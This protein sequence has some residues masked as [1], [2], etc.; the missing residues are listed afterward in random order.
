MPRKSRYNLSDQVGRKFNKL[1][2]VRAIA[3]KNIHCECICGGRVITTIY[4][5]EYGKTASCGC[6]EIANRVRHGH[7][8]SQGKSKEYLVWDGMIQRCTNPNSRNYKWYG[9]RGIKVCERW[10]DFNN[11]LKDMGDRP[12]GM[13][14]DRRDSNGDYY[15]D[16]CRWASKETQMRNIRTNHLLTAKGK[17]QCIASWVSELGINRNTLVKRLRSGMPHE[18]ALFTP[19]DLSRSHK[20]ERN[21]NES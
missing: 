2:I 20:P 17:T 7:N 18:D 13:T 6:G 10:R 3:L 11:F 14:L 15:K 16:N 8:T 12:S 5:L 9:A 1:T 4:Q 19:V 21:Q